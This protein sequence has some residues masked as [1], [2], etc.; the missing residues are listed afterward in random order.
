MRHLSMILSIFTRSIN[1]K[2]LADIPG[3][4]DA[5]ENSMDS[6]MIAASDIS[7]APSAIVSSTTIRFGK[8]LNFEP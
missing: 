1:S 4:D 6:R 3:F 7:L 2:R 5:I 8:I